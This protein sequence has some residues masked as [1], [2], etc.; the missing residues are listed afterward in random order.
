MNARRFSVFSR[1]LVAALAL[2]PGAARGDPT[3]A[4][5]NAAVQRS[6][7]SEANPLKPRALPGPVDAVV[8]NRPAAPPVEPPPPGFRVSRVIFEGNTVLARWELDRLRRI[9]EGRTVGVA[10]F[11]LLTKSVEKLYRKK[12]YFLAR[13]AVPPQEVQ[14]G[15]VKVV[16][17]EGKYG[18]VSVQGN[19]HYSSDFILKYLRAATAGGLVRE[20]PLLE[21]LVQL[22]QLPDLAV[23]SVFTP[24]QVAGTTDVILRAHDV[25]PL[26]LA[27]DYNNLGSRLVGRN[28]AGLTLT[29]GRAFVEGDDLVLRV[30]VPFPSNSDPFYQASY[31]APVGPGTDR[32]GVLFSS[33]QTRVRGSGLDPLDIRGSADI[34]GFTWQRPLVSL[35]DEQSSLSASYQDMNLRNFVL[36]DRVTSH[37][38]VRMVTAGYTLSQRSGTQQVLASALLSQGLGTAFGGSSD[39]QALPSRVGAGNAF[40]KLNF[41][42]TQIRQLTAREFL[43]L[44]GSAQVATEPL[45]VAEQFAIGGLDSVRGFTASE[46][47]GDD[48]YSLSAEYRRQLA[49]HKQDTLQ[50]AAFLENGLVRLKRPQA[51]EA[52]TRSLTGAGV[53]LRAFAGND[54][55]V[56]LDLGVPLHPSTNVDGERL[57]LYAQASYRY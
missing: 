50:A 38:K 16:I 36:N 42:G 33:A 25:K 56:R 54:A 29:A 40:T 8:V 7:D 5:A 35:Q 3:A 20:R 1:L 34:A 2:A 55:S 51:G 44:R 15:D 6:T 45:V 24:G 39:A 41:D 23:Q 43:V 46:G 11:T 10:D 17:S 4:Q 30:A 57:L 14:G 21:A 53:G 9:V 52:G 48:G 18:Q 47:L 26:H 27:F 12:G 22:N 13:A 49:Q 32:A 31:T 19:E 37:D 28:R